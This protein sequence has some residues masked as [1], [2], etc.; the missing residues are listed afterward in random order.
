MSRLSGMVGSQHESRSRK[1]RKKKWV[2]VFVY[3]RGGTD[4][5]RYVQ[6]MDNG[7]PGWTE[8]TTFICTEV[9][10][11]VDFNSFTDDCWYNDGVSL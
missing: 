5:L 1:E 11:Y 10:M 9:L 2:G 3:E 7:L 4:H 6:N 8:L